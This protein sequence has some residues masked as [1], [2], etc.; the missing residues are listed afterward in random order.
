MFFIILSEI[1]WGV[2]KK[3]MP[4]RLRS[5]RV[6]CVFARA[7]ACSC[8]LCD[9]CWTAKKK[10]SN[11]KHL[12][13][14]NGSRETASLNTTNEQYSMPEKIIFKRA[15][16]ESLLLLLRR[17]FPLPPHSNL[18][19][20]HTHNHRRHILCIHSRMRAPVCAVRVCVSRREKRI[21]DNTF[22]QFFFIFCGI[23]SN[24]QSNNI[25]EWTEKLCTKPKR[26]HIFQAQPV[27]PTTFW[28]STATAATRKKN[29]HGGNKNKRKDFAE[30]NQDDC[31][32]FTSR[33]NVPCICV[34][35]CRTT[36]NVH[37]FQ[38]SYFSRMDFFLPSSRLRIAFVRDAIKLH[39]RFCLRSRSIQAGAACFIFQQTHAI[40][41]HVCQWI[42]RKFARG[43]RI[44]SKLGSS[45]F[46]YLPRM[47]MENF[48]SHACV[49]WP[50]S[51]S[52]WKRKE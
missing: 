44:T 36:L 15:S 14:E 26:S 11:C 5:T 21:I 38:F 31:F 32:P 39:F 20:C 25:L 10:Y 12:R 16:Y 27:F 23:Q 33:S 1:P 24:T 40:S 47:N 50:S 48:V 29:I 18:N 13:I 19:A 51:S 7:R 2:Q 3:M 28:Y 43:A 34:C 6:E 4:H 22:S 46:W 42:N 37:H 17:L 45:I 41:D 52:D 49:L 9:V 8:V 35:V 30:T